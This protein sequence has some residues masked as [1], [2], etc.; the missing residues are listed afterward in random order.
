M[1]IYPVV[2]AIAMS[3]CQMAFAKDPVPLAKAPSGDRT[4]HPVLFV[5]G[6]GSNSSGTWGAKGKEIYCEDFELLTDLPPRV[7]SYEWTNEY[8]GRTDDL[9]FPRKKYLA[10]FT[11]TVS[12][13][14]RCSNTPD[15]I[16]AGKITL[17]PLEIRY[18]RDED[19]D[20][21]NSTRPRPYVLGKVTRTKGE[22]ISLP[23]PTYRYPAAKEEFDFGKYWLIVGGS[24]LSDDRVL[25]GIS[26]GE[27]QDYLA[28][29]ME[30]E[31][32]F[33]PFH[34]LG[35][36]RLILTKNAY[37]ALLKKTGINLMA[38]SLL[39]RSRAVMAARVDSVSAWHPQGDWEQT[40]DYPTSYKE[41]GLA[42]AVAEMFGIPSKNM[43]EN[44]AKIT[45]GLYFFNAK[46]QCHASSHVGIG[47]E[48]DVMEEWA[49]PR[50]DTSFANY[51]QPNQLLDKMV[52]SL[53]DFYGKGK[54]HDDSNAVIDIV[55]HSQGGLI[56]RI[57]IDKS[58]SRDGS[59]PVNHINRIVTIDTPHRGSALATSSEW[60]DNG[61]PND[62]GARYPQLAKFKNWLLG[63][64]STFV[65]KGTMRLVSGHGVYQAMTTDLT[66]DVHGPAFG[67][68]Q[69]S[70]ST[71]TKFFW[72]AHAEALGFEEASEH[73]ELAMNDLWDV[74]RESKH[75]AWSV[76]SDYMRELDAMRYPTYPR[77]ESNIHVTHFYSGGLPKHFL[78]QFKA[79]LMEMIKKTCKEVIKEGEP[80]DYIR[81]GESCR[82]LVKRVE[83]G[84]FGGSWPK[85][86]NRFVALDKDW[87][88]RSDLVVENSSQKGINPKTGYSEDDTP[89]FHAKTFHWNPQTVI[90]GALSDDIA[91]I[92]KDMGL[93]PATRQKCDVLSELGAFNFHSL[94]SLDKFQ[95]ECTYP[96][97]LK[98]P[99]TVRID[100]AHILLEFKDATPSAK[101][102]LASFDYYF[103]A[104]PGKALDVKTSGAEATVTVEHV[105]GAIHKATIRPAA[106]AEGDWPANGEFSLSIQ[107]ADGTPR[108]ASND[109]SRPVV[110]GIALSI[111]VYDET[112]RRVGGLVPSLDTLDQNVAS[113]YDVTVEAKERSRAGNVSQPS[114]RVTNVGDLALPGFRLRYTFKTA[115][116][117]ELRVY[118]IDRMRNATWN[119]VDLGE[120]LHA[121]EI[122]YSGV[123]LKKGESVSPVDFELFHADWSPWNRADDHSALGVGEEWTLAPFVELF[124]LDGGRLWGISPDMIPR[125]STE[126]EAPRTSIRV[127]GREESGFYNKSTHRLRVIND[128]DVP[129]EGFAVYDY[130]TSEGPE[131]LFDAW[132]VPRCAVSKEHLGGL[133]WRLVYDCSDV[134]LDPGQ[135][136]DWA[137]WGM[138]VDRHYPDWSAWD[139]SNDW[140]AL[141]SEWAEA[142]RVRVVAKDGTP[143]W[144]EAPVFAVPV[145]ANFAMGL[146]GPLG[147]EFLPPL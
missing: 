142:T 7:D 144:G 147:P 108:D 140:S 1:K 89:E 59:N 8:K 138:L 66:I 34:M 85:L 83:D 128:G 50:W 139:A 143:L 98:S 135:E 87:P 141:A 45:N 86:V 122:V 53:D 134:V 119:L 35:Q 70:Y 115:K 41:D 74:V 81:E 111:P 113:L 32:V 42:Y 29:D 75:L 18:N 43:G 12:Y 80:F 27:L 91:D 62:N 4:N 133:E 61:N 99:A 44:F 78:E 96:T 20:T 48:C 123:D 131:P 92:V 60:L 16:Y 25:P 49:N 15:P 121:V 132:D 19:Q 112:G 137:S 72:S 101:S 69:I 125:D 5:P 3:L 13:Q 6:L 117:P 40:L 146:P 36:T 57:A 10:K 97:S 21:L 79:H 136:I 93:A 129:I 107:Y 54:W 9:V 118:W 71:N 109:P 46:G 130:F 63:K 126:G 33:E 67:P 14:Y 22:N 73:E 104:E 11:P 110:D 23:F 52:R 68:Y 77:N 47:A 30:G 38:D 65:I 106:P 2:I 145:P 76:E 100:S 94:V 127:V 39:A 116:K 17:T 90:H 114:V 51:G 82:K 102:K 55:A 24:K 26:F 58:R 124:T 103:A 31:N 84:G 37:V 95:K 120:N 28:P 64:D 88:Y 105:G 56:T